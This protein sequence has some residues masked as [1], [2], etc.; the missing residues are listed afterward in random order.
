MCYNLSNWRSLWAR[1]L[2]FE[3]YVINFYFYHALLCR[4]QQMALT[5]DFLFLLPQTLQCFPCVLNSML[6]ATDCL[7]V[8][9]LSQEYFDDKRS[10]I[11]CPI[12][13]VI[14]TCAA[15]GIAIFFSV[16]VGYAMWKRLHC[17]PCILM[18]W[19]FFTEKDLKCCHGLCSSVLSV[20]KVVSVY[21]RVITCRLFFLL[22][23]I[24]IES[25]RAL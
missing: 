14:F 9:C 6:L 24:F 15:T 11:I 17:A 8:F 16:L 1:Q 2:V 4:L 19:Q 13:L 20:S 10:P 22:S 25:Y 18:S 7:L 12:D 5:W 3:N 21:A 23:V